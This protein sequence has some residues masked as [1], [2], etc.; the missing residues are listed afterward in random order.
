MKLTV[1]GSGDAFGSGARFQTSFHIAS[2]TK[3][4][5]VDCGATTLVGLAREDLNPN[6]IETII[7]TH[8]HGDHF[9][10]LI[11]F[12]LQARH[13]G[14]RLAPLEIIGPPGIEDRVLQ[15]S[16]LLFPGSTVKAPKFDLTFREFDTRSQVVS[17]NARLQAYEVSH[18]SG[19]LSAALRLELDNRT[20]AFSG[21]TEWVDGL[22]DCARDADL[23]L[24][25]CYSAG[26]GARY[27]LNWP[28]LIQHFDKITASRIVITHM[29][30]SMLG[31]R[32]GLS[33]PRV[34]F[35]HDRLAFDL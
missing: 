6:D 20:I 24:C 7:I 17:G 14:K 29:S 22:I 21:D 32:H 11:F 18:P 10:G 35:A 1:I 3:T 9:A 30:N 8:L 13:P 2:A 31:A 12:I 26:E 5:L 25:E 28:T 27:H 19:S 23:F 16:E 4:L 33:H 34:T 15:T